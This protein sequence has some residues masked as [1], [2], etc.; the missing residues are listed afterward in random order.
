MSPFILFIATYKQI[1]G[2]SGPVKGVR[3]T[4]KVANTKKG[5]GVKVKNVKKKK[6][7]NSKKQKME[8]LKKS[9][10]KS[11]SKKNS[12]KGDTCG[13]IIPKVATKVFAKL[14]D[15]NIFYNDHFEDICCLASGLRSTLGFTWTD[16]V[17]NFDVSQGICPYAYA[18][19]PELLS[20]TAKTNNETM[21]GF[22]LE[23]MDMDVLKELNEAIVSSFPIVPEDFYA[24][25]QQMEDLIKQYVAM[26]RQDMSADV[27]ASPLLDTVEC[28]T[29]KDDAGAPS[30]D[31][32]PFCG[33]MK[34]LSGL[35]FLFVAS[36]VILD[37]CYCHYVEELG[38]G[39]SSC[40]A[41]E[42]TVMLPTPS[43][44]IL[45]FLSS[46]IAASPRKSLCASCHSFSSYMHTASE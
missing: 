8:K 35:N 16:M 15:Y 43:L 39:S 18:T 6:E 5:K 27:S 12:K 3:A 10:K 46:C 14:D 32:A 40:V 17:D 20:D 34:D 30:Y 13:G 41:R 33:M 4:K 44:N 1:K 24:D 23:S 37:A 36:P 11:K 26:A 29:T 9:K 7:E 31:K 42:P 22:D 28:L 45:S 2:L 25:M 38:C 19:D 21:A